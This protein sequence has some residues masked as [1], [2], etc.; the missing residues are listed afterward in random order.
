MGI[1]DKQ[2]AA[3]FR[4]QFDVSRTVK[5]IMHKKAKLARV[6]TEI[7]IQKKPKRYTKEE[8]S[9]IIEHKQAGKTLEQMITNFQQKF[10][11]EHMNEGLKV[12]WYRFANVQSG[13]R[14]T[15]GKEQSKK[16]ASSES[17][18]DQ[19]PINRESTCT[20]GTRKRKRAAA[21][22]DEQSDAS[23]PQDNAEAARPSDQTMQHAQR[24][25]RP[26][27]RRAAGR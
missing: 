12:K 18:N 3:E 17:A 24:T 9:F 6:H 14:A 8:K 4:A 27:G 15:R 21:R 20:P 5:S 2:L 13:Q 10:G 1:E 7:T 26:G 11:S 25:D 16:F 23:S 19:I 22:G